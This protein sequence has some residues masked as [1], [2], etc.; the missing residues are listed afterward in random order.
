MFMHH[1]LYLYTY[2]LSFYI[3]VAFVSRLISLSVITSSLS[4]VVLPVRSSRFI[5]SVEGS[6]T[7]FGEFSPLW[8]NFKIFANLVRA[9]FV[10]G[11]I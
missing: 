1:S 11:K 8:Y 10:C 7:R 3:Y 6:V 9:S 2:I 5:L 4:V